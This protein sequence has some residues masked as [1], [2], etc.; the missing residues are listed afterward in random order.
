MVLCGTR[1]DDGSEI[2]VYYRPML[3]CGSIA[4]GEN[5]AAEKV[6]P[7]WNGETYQVLSDLWLTDQ[8]D[9]A[10]EEQAALPEFDPAVHLT[11]DLTFFS[12]ASNGLPTPCPSICWSWVVTLAGGQYCIRRWALP[13]PLRPQGNPGKLYPDLEFL[14][15]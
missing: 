4:L 2:W 3:D 13:P 10:A 12:Q 1:G 9:Q 7:F 11:E 5:L 8:T 15:P 6:Q 14:S